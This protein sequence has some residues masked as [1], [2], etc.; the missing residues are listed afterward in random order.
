V[1]VGAP[2]DRHQTTPV[3]GQ[4]FLYR[5]TGSAW[6]PSELLDSDDARTEAEGFGHAVAIDG[7]TVVVGAP[8]DDENGIDSGAAY[9]F[10]IR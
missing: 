4:A 9:V 8:K 6:M 5:W 3:A 10:R 1:V 2:W 7:R